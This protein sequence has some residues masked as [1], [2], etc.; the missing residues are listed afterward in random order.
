VF[1]ARKLGEGLVEFVLDVTQQHE[2]REALRESEERLRRFGEA[3][4]DVL[5]IRHA[6][7]LQWEYL[8]PAFEAIYGVSREA[9]LTGD[10]LRRWTELILPEDC[11]HALGHIQR[12]RNG[13]RVGFEY[14]IVRPVNGEVRWVRNTDFPLLDESGRVGRIGGVGRDITEEK[15]TAERMQVM[16]VELQHRT[17][18]LIAVVRSIASQTMAQTGP[19]GAFQ[20][21][22]FDR[23]AALSRVQGLLS[24]SD[25]EPITL[26]ALIRTELEALGAMDGAADRVR[27][28]GPNVRLRNTIVQT[29][30]LAL[31]ELATNARKYGALSNG[32][33]QLGVTW[34]VRDADGAGPSA[35]A[36]VD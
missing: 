2:A 29:L 34:S 10:T 3:S 5:W 32:D 1:A 27:L 16:V 26:D 24:R 22:F 12:V 35:R 8:S 15:E 4:S 14:R 30:A 33:G 20:D 25:E 31:H 11:E 18:N 17:R 9:A 23:L 7:T 13:E 28:E 36:R 6:E 21:E 19:T